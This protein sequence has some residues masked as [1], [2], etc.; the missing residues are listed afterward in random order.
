VQITEVSVVGVRT[1]V[2]VFE[3]TG[4]PLRFVLM[5]TFHI[6]RPDYYRQLAER[7][8]RCDLIVA[9]G[10]DRP[11]S[12]GLAYAI[13]LRISWQ[14]RGASLVHQDIDYQALGVPIIWP[15]DLPSRGRRGLGWLGWLDIV[16]LVPLLAFI[17]AIGGRHWLFRQNFE[18]SDDSVPRLRWSFLTKLFLVARDRKLVAAV[19]KIHEERGGER[20]DVGIIFGAGHFP[21]VV[22]ALTG[23]LGYR[24]QRGGEWLVAID[25]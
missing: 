20:I 4:S 2:L 23:R 22:R 5:P 7:L 9:E 24:P 15:D 10:D 12:T 19:T 25:F 1:S 8:A 21:A 17:M 13:A 18:L 16:V 6:G 3:R 11:S 14:R